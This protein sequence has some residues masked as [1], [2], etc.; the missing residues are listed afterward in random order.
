MTTYTVYNVNDSSTAESGLT[1][2]QAA[3]EVLGHDD[4]FYELRHEDDDAGR[5]AWYLYCS[6]RSRNC[7]GGAGE[8]RRAFTDGYARHSRQIM[9]YATGEAAAW[10]EIAEMVIDSAWLDPL[11]IM[12]DADFEATN[13]DD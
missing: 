10:Q 12:T 5:K 13:V 2:V 9:S 8:M 1:A 3:Q 7:H 11:N 6:Q 4:D